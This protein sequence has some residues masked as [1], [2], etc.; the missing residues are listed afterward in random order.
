MAKSVISIQHIG[1]K[2]AL[3]PCMHLTIKHTLILL[4]SVIATAAYSQKKTGTVPQRKCATMEVLQQMLKQNPALVNQ[5]KQEGERLQQEYLQKKA[6]AKETFAAGTTVIPVVVHIISN[7]PAA[8]SDREV[9]DQIEALNTDFAGM[10]AD[11]AVIVPEFKARF[12]HSNIRFTLARKDPNGAYTSG[13]ERKTSSATYTQNNFANAKYTSRGGLDA[14]DAS[15]YYN[16]WV[17]NFSDGVLG[18]ATF[19]YMLPAAEQGVVI[20]TI[21]FGLN[22]CRV[23]AEFNL[24]RTL[25]HE[26]G[27][28]FY[29][30]HIWGDDD[31]ACDGVDFKTQ[32]GY[33]LPASCTDD[34]PNQADN[35]SGFMGGYVTDSCS[36]LKPGIMYENYMD[37]TNDVSYGMFTLNQVC[38]MSNALDRY[39]NT[40]YTSD[41]ATMP[42]SVTDAYL[43]NMQPGGRPCAVAP[44]VCS[45]TPLTATL[46]NSG[47][48]VLTSLSFHVQYDAGAASTVSWAGS[49]APGHDTTVNLGNLSNTGLHTITVYTT[50]PNG[51]TD[52]Y[53]KN[54]TL[55]KQVMVT[56]AT[57]AAP[58]SESFDNTAFPPAGWSVSNP[59]NS[60][61]TWTRTA[62]GHNGAG[63]AMIDNYND[64]IPGQWDDLISPPI[65][66]GNADSATLSFWLA[67]RA[68][69]S[70]MQRGASY[71]DGLEVWV[72]YDCGGS[73]V[74]VYR[75]GPPD[76]ATVTGTTTSAFTPTASQWRQETINLTPYLSK[77]HKLTLLFR[78]I[79]GNG[80]RLYID[81]INISKNTFS[82]NDAGVVSITAPAFVC[83]GN[84]VNASITLQNNGLAALRSATIGYRVDNGTAASVSWT[85]NL[86]K[87]DSTVVTLPALSA[88]IGQ[89]DLIVYTSNPN[90][91][92]DEYTA[93]DTL[94]KGFAITGTVSA[95]LTEGFE[96]NGFPPAGWGIYNP[97][98]SITWSPVRKAATLASGADATAAYMNN[99]AYTGNN[100][101][102]ELRTPS[103]Q[104][105]NVDSVFLKFDVAATYNALG[106]NFPLDT[107]EVLLTS[108]CGN[109]FRSVYKKY[110]AALQTASNA[111]ASTSF[112]P[113]TVDVYRRDSVN[114]TPYVPSTG[115]FQVVFRSTSNNRNN[116][117][118]DNVNVY[119]KTLPQKL[120]EQGYL[121][122]P[123]PFQTYFI[124]QHYHPPTTLQGIA[125]Y[126]T[127]GA[128]LYANQ[129]SGNANSFITI[130]LSRFASGIYFVRLFYSDHTVT[131]KVLKTH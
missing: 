123:S 92:A 125:V 115:V 19:P 130:D 75:K 25:V 16:V 44:V 114:L 108:D 36:T 6:A 118:L 29:L 84:T 67:Y 5:W 64:S 107:L 52:S 66:F 79:N 99:F 31:G 104:Y 111:S 94:R 101:I 3:Y 9:L 113:A 65:D 23:N 33:D 38:R 45:N 34:T 53:L 72:S 2:Q 91:V 129:Y 74:P 7:N 71:A 10:N 119:T 105:S 50:N 103:I 89:H 20:N 127:A 51:T 56:G 60:V 102:D 47:N 96:N 8:I 43:V 112:V 14:W 22:Q 78:N 35:S 109:S 62:T 68:Y 131:E 30:Y 120:K 88:A 80:N 93:N 39:R 21:S 117:Y 1:L 15:K 90:G 40:L 95:P 11:S 82:Q 83:T 87:G 12:G 59:D 4:L 106:S 122:Y 18:I 28:Y 116:I 61:F 70:D 27:H 26:T 49:L 98:R 126:N 100:N 41:G 32:T 124:V 97:D 110:G 48:T 69:P 128:R 55:V 121:I 58:V 86:A 24:G 77:G 42:G 73:Y 46:R 76:L 17:V 63:A 54:D 85:G 81:D 57:A 37:Y 13:I